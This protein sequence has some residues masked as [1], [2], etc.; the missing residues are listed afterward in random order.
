[1]N[2]PFVGLG[3]TGVQGQHSTPTLD[4]PPEAAAS[5]SGI[6]GLSSQGERARRV[7]GAQP[8]APSLGEPG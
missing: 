2:F 4:I 6:F 1:M 3:E 7:S 5:S 8:V